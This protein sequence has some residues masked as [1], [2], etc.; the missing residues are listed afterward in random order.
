MHEMRREFLNGRLLA[1]CGPSGRLVPPRNM[2]AAAQADELAALGRT[3]SSI[4]PSVDYASWWTR[5]ED[6]LL[7]GLS[8]R[9]WP[10]IAD[11]RRTA[12]DLQEAA[13]A[14]AA[15]P[16]GG[17]EEAPHVYSLVEEWWLRFGAPG[18]GAMPRAHHARRLVD[19]GHASWGRLWRA[20]F[21]I[22]DSARPEAMSERDAEHESRLSEIRAM[23]HRLSGNEAGNSTQKVRTTE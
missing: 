18:P 8:S 10:T 5:F 15:R 11:I 1:L 20:G 21:P 22:P 9:A 19:A 2:G 16:T 23:G 3:V 4:A 14:S 12:R 6:A 17:A 7:G 13:R